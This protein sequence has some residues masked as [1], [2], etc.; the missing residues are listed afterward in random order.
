MFRRNFSLTNRFFTA[1]RSA[2]NKA[3]ASCFAIHDEAFNSSRGKLS[4]GAQPA[5]DFRAKGVYL[6]PAGTTY[7][8][9]K[10]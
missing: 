10:S 1:A 4:N 3:I 7:R 8:T 2:F 5:I 6:R 9:A